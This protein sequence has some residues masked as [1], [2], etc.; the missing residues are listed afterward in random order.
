[1][2]SPQ[3]DQAKDTFP[4]GG[5]ENEGRFTESMDS[6]TEPVAQPKKV[7]RSRQGELDS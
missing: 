3:L 2:S 1:M 5:Q 4:T 7:G 6:G